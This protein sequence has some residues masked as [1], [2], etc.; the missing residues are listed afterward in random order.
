MSFILNP[1]HLH[2][3]VEQSRLG[4]LRL[5]VMKQP[6]EVFPGSQA[7]DEAGDVETPEFCL[8]RRSDAADSGASNW[9]G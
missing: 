9:A 1:R 7:R 5:R 4:V 8:P 2:A 6:D 3:F